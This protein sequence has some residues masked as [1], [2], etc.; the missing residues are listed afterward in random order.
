MLL[1]S[2][3]MREMAEIMV[4]NKSHFCHFSLVRI[5]NTDYCPMF[6][7][8]ALMITFSTNRARN[9][10]KNWCVYFFN[11]IPSIGINVMSLIQFPLKVL[12]SPKTSSP[13]IWPWSLLTIIISTFVYLLLIYVITIQTLNWIWCTHTQKNHIINATVTLKWSWGPQFFLNVIWMFADEFM[14]SFQIFCLSWYQRLSQIHCF[15][16]CSKYGPPLNMD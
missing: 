12:L 15:R 11:S 9:R 4:P 10:A 16:W 3:P 2:L 5:T 13:L 14:C 1:H 6:L 8:A 7:M